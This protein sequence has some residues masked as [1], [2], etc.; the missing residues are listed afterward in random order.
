MFRRI[1]RREGP[2][3]IGIAQRLEHP[4]ALGDH[5]GGYRV[6]NDVG[7]R[8][9]HVEERVD[10]QQ[11]RDA[12]NR[13][14]ELGERGGDH[15]QAGARHPG[16][17]LRADHQRKQ[18]GDLRAGAQ[19]DAIGLRHEDRGEAHVQHRT[20]EVEAVAERQDKARNPP[21]HAEPVQLVEQAWQAGFRTRGRK[22]QQDRLADVTHQRQHAAAKERPAHPDQQRPQQDQPTIELGHQHA[23]GDE[24]AQPLGSDHRG[25]RAEHREWR[26]PHY[27]TGNVQH[28]RGQRLGPAHQR[29]APFTQRGQANACEHRKH[30]D[31]QDI[32][33][34]HRIESAGRE[35][36][37][38]E[39][40]ERQV[41]D[42]QVTHRSSRLERQARA[43]LQRVHQDQP[44][45]EREQ[46][47]G[48]E[49]G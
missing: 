20:I 46:A 49:P 48:H 5:R 44:E 40:A 38:D 7:G 27:I 25:Q 11:Q 36:F 41:L 22:R 30:Q 26:D 9:A 19:V 42:R 34:R 23:I 45:P 8:T 33:L 24:D 17:A 18:H 39:V 3:G 47:R 32:V 37:E 13:Q 6:A 31:L 21:R 43:R 4:F 1:V 10:A 2:L 35:Y 16:D 29:R 12:F 15:H 14:V 28:Q